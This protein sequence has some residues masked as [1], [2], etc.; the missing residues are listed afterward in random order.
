MNISRFFKLSAVIAGTGMA[1]GEDRPR[2]AWLSPGQARRLDPLAL[3]ACAAV[4]RLLIGCA[5]LAPDTALVLG[6][7]WGCV[8]STQRFLDGI[9]TYG[10]SGSSPTA[11]TISVHHHVA[12]VLGELLHLH[13][14]A[15]TVCAGNRSGLTALRS[16]A[17]MLAAGRAPAV[18]VVVADQANALM[19]RM[20][21]AL[22][23][24]PWPL[25]EGAVALLL[26][27]AGPGRHVSFVA[28]AAELVVDAGGVS[29][30]EE[31]ALLRAARGQERRCAAALHGAW[32]PTAALAA[33]PWDDPRPVLVREIDKGQVLE[34]WLTL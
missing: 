34:A 9:S 17:L 12:G 19:R 1:V 29:P 7:A 6:T 30:G 8:A 21:P 23:Q 4:D 20:V 14:P 18:L 15:T 33:V 26:K 22:A 11:F 25:G 10:E 27:S 2:P 13:G 16:A 24:T 28:Q 31:R 3:Q 32:W 5:P